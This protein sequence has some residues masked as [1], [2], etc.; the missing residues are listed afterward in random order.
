MDTET[1]RWVF[2]AIAT[3]GFIVWLA[4]AQFVGATIRSERDAVRR[5]MGEFGLD[6]APSGRLQVGRTEVEG[7]PAELAAKAAGALVKSG[8]GPLGPV[9][10]LSKTDERLVFEG[11]GQNVVGQPSWRSVGRGQM[12]F[13]AAGPNRTAIAYAVELT[14]GQWLLTCALIFNALGLA[15]LLVGS[16]LMLTWV[17][18]NLN[19]AI[20]AQ[21]VQM[22]QVVHFLWPPFLFA[23]LYRSVR[24]SVRV[25]FEVFVHNLPYVGES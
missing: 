4:A 18:P 5:T 20:R 13:T 8:Q 25:G 11:A 17:I 19:P 6:K 14:S 15:A 7:Q 24:R 10:I 12:Q 9:K 22:V 2:Y 21:T 23:G 1:A 3:I 16:A